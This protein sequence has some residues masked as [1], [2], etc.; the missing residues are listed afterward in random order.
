[1]TQLN[2]GDGS[3][4]RAEYAALTTSC[5][6]ADLNGRTRIELTGAD[7]ASFL[8]NLS[9]N[10]IKKL[11]SGSGCEAFLLDARG[12]VLA[13][14]FVVCRPE[15]LVLET[16][17]GQEERLIA[18]LDRY[19]IR[20]RVELLGRSGVWGELLVAGPNTPEIV[21]KLTAAPLPAAP[22]AH[23]DVSLAGRPATLVRVELTRPFGCLVLCERAD[24]ALVGQAI[25]DAGAKRCG[26]EAFEMARIEAGFPWYGPDISDKN[27]PQ[28]VARDALAISFVKGCYIGQET[29]ARI[30]ALGHVNKTLV[31]VR[32]AGDQVPAAGTELTAGGQGAGQVTS[33]VFSPRLN[34]PLALAYVRRGSEVPGTVLESAVGSAEVVSLPV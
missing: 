2:Q 22:L 15:S 6:L 4:P 11:P 16:V 18:H 31:G 5:G 12:H 32:F 24:V 8:H 9:T 28:E 13:H 10:E 20:E 17:P 30:D 34:T 29:V 21:A 26:P 25:V 7:R 3:D 33:A 19:L 1:M 27:L 23:V 14:M